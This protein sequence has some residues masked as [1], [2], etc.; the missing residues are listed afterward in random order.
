MRESNSKTAQ[1]LMNLY[2]QAHVINGGWVAVNAVFIAEATA[3]V[4]EELKKLPTG[5]R[6]VTH[7]ENLKRGRTAANSIA[8]DLMPYGGIM[9]SAPM[10]NDDIPTGISETDFASIERALDNFQPNQE[11]LDAIK[12]LPA[13]QQ[14]ADR[15]LVGIRATIAG[16]ADLLDKWRVVYNAD[17]AFSLWS[18]ASDILSWTPTERMRAEVQADLPEYESYLPMFGDAGKELLGKLRAYVSSV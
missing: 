10:D 4:L 2:R 12:S 17:R 14:F 5:G 18:R 13:I 3:P 7:I 9:E 15:W 6:L 8:R 16:R 1:R 11:S